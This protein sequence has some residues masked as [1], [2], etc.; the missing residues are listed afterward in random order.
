MAIQGVNASIELSSRR[1]HRSR[2]ELRLELA[3]LRSDTRGMSLTWR[4]CFDWCAHAFARPAASCRRGRGFTLLT[5]LMG[6]WLCGA[7]LALADPDPIETM[8]RVA[9]DLDL[10][11]KMPA[12]EP[13]PPDIKWSNV[14]WH[15]PGSV[16]TWILYGALAVGF[17]FVILALRGTLPTLSRRSRLKARQRDAAVLLP[18]DEALGRMSEAGDDAEELAR[19]GLFAEAMHM[20]L[21]RSVAE[22][23]KRLEVTIADSLTSREI[24]QRLALPEVGR[25]ALA[26]LISRVELVHFGKRAAG[27][28]DYGACR[29]SFDA[30][31]GAMR[32][33]AALA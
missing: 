10:Q 13:P 7:G 1:N 4:R 16:A 22:L 27:R 18:N 19:R 6:V 28:D 32:R 8:S 30:L 2:G 15:I 20:L 26:D 3:R 33:P 31:I 23:R 25:R 14:H 24:L 17:V 12:D 29:A 5:I 11:T 21:L 9:R